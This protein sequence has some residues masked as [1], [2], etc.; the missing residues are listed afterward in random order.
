MKETVTSVRGIILSSEGILVVDRPET[1]KHNPGLTEFPGGKVDPHESIEAAALR[2]IGTEEVSIGFTAL[3][4]YRLCIR[5]PLRGDMHGTY[6]SYA[7]VGAAV[8]ELGVGSTPEEVIN[9]RWV[10]TFGELMDLPLTSDSRKIAGAF[11]GEIIYFH[12]QILDSSAFELASA[13]R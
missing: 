4:D 10:S 1:T 11:A 3:T 5:R 9:P 7:M 13:R 12:S 8:T 6:Q 2:E